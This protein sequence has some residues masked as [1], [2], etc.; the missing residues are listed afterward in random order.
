MPPALY[1]MYLFRVDP[2]DKDGKKLLEP[3]VVYDEEAHAAAEKEGYR[4]SPE[5]ARGEPRAHPT[6]PALTDPDVHARGLAAGEKVKPHGP[7]YPMMLFSSYDGKKI[8]ESTVY[9]P[10]QHDALL[11]QGSWFESPADAKKHG[12]SRKEAGDA[13]AAEA[14]A[15]P[16]SRIKDAEGGVTNGPGEVE[17]KLPPPDVNKSTVAQVVAW[18]ETTTVDDL[19]TLAVLASTEEE[20]AK[21]KGV[22][23]AI[24]K[25]VEVLTAPPDEDE[26][27]KD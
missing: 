19:E 22:L 9:S 14:P 7:L 1:P 20:G 6:K 24:E 5:E 18:L 26:D 3:R 16:P 23:D 13:Q 25:R 8:L 4:E 27:A 10:E 21:R 12:L 17:G 11:A 15:G 2:E